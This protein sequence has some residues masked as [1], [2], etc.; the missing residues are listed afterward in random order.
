[1][2]DDKLRAESPE[3][4][5]EYL[6]NRNR[7]LIEVVNNIV[8]ILG[9]VVEF[10]NLDSGVH[11]KRTKAFTHI[12]GM[13]YMK[14]EPDSGLTE[15]A[16]NEISYASAL[17]DI[18]KIAIP[19]SI[20]MKPGKLTKDEFEIMK[21]HTTK[22]DEILSGILSGL[23][24]DAYLKYCMEI[25]RH[26]HEKYDGRG[27][28][29]GLKGD[30]IPLSAQLVSIADCYDALI[31]ERVYKAAYPKDTAFDMICGGECGIFNPKIMNCFM[32][33]REELE[34]EAD[35]LEEP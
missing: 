34:M 1:M 4:R 20:L 30:E 17:H 28:P 21:T 18:G 33:S 22:G 27:Y 11:V 13:N 19:D 15:Q 23:E 14:L 12:M 25:I 3:Q 16:V 2:S 29:D 9:T 35:R 10:R 31:S 7:Y 8:D 24:P 26:H 6:E 32:V 5:I